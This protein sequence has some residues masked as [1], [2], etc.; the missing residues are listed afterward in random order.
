MAS[1]T[2]DEHLERVFRRLDTHGNGQLDRN[3]IHAALMERDLPCSKASLDRFF[4]RADRDG[5][6]VVT[7]LEFK[8]FCKAQELELRRVYDEVDR[9]G[10]GKLTAKEIRTGAASLGFQLSAEQVRAL[11]QRAD[12]D[13]DGVVSFQE[14]AAFLRLLPVVNQA[15][16]FEAFGATVLVDHAQGENTPPAERTSRP[17]STEGLI[18]LLAA[19]LYSG[20]IAGATSRTLTA[21]IDRLKMLMQTAPP[22]QHSVGMLQCM[23]SIYAEGGVPAFFRGNS[24]NVLKI[25][26]ETAIK[27]LAFDTLKMTIARDPDAVTVSERFAAGGAAGALSQAAIYPLEIA[28]TRLAVSAP[29]TYA[30]LVDCIGSIVRVEGMAALYQGLTTSIVGIVPYAGVDLSINSLLKEV[31]G[32]YYAQRGEEPG[33]PAVL[34]CGMGSST[35]AMLVTY[36]LNLIRTRLQASGMPGAPTFS[37]PLDVLRQTLAAGGAR[38]L[39]QGIGPNMLKVLPATSISYAVYDWLERPK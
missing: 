27:F 21:P 11:L 34:G 8:A 6:G 14:W 31:V 33:I 32:R 20:G 29:G 39:F 28:K 7:L 10:D 37:G 17:K 16:V 3:E 15:A 13:R 26:P 22:G 30:G 19:K 12:R 1:S 35:C 38:A 24:V 36:P 25:A 9:N 5:D 23:R 2:I 18:A 4:E